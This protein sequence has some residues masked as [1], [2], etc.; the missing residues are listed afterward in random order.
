MNQYSQKTKPEKHVKIAGANKHINLSFESS[1][2]HL[3]GLKHSPFFVSL[4]FVL[5]QQSTVLV[6]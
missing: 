2:T 4:N 6:P 1:E 5:V 3:E